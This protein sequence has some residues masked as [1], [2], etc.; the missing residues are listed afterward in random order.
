MRDWDDAFNN[1]GYVGGSAALP[2]FWA[3]RAAKYRAQTRVDA[4][5]SYG[6]HER[7]QFDL[8]WPD[9][10]PRGLVVFVHG[11]FWMRLDKSYW[12]DLAEGARARGWAVA[13][14]SYTLTPEARISDITLQIGA[15][16]EA[17]GKRVAGP[18]RLAGHSAGGHLVTRM[19]CENS[20]LSAQ[21]RERVDHVLSISG[22]H[23]LRPLR[24]TAMNDTLGLTASEA[25]EESPALLAPVFGARVSIWV[26]GGERPEFIRQAR[27][28]DMI[29]N[30]LDAQT[31]L[32]IDDNHNH[33]T[34]LEGLRSPNTRICTALLAAGSVRRTSL[35]AGQGAD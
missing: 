31:E 5:I 4:D 28:L 7:E 17:A 12:T 10:K 23:D 21:T 30:G 11:G 27:L 2:D 3:G 9:A 32:I 20:P 16:I 22:L 26:G 35:E 24:Q 1:M 15:A 19:I 34:I 25:T 14:P 29:W 33:F 8:I 18:I 6:T 13:I